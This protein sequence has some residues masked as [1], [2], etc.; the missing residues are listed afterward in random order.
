MKRFTILITLLIVALVPTA[1]FAQQ[2]EITP[3]GGYRFSDDFYDYY[4]NTRY[5]VSDGSSY[6]LTFDYTLNL[7]MQVEFLWSHQETRFNVGG[8]PDPEG[9]FNLGIDY[10]H[11]GGVQLFENGNSTPFLVGTLG[12]T[13]INP[14]DN[15]YSSDTR[16]SLAAGGGVKF[17][18]SEHLGVR[19]DGRVYGTYVNGSGGVFCGPYG[20]NFGYGGSLYWQVEFTV[21]LIFSGG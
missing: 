17:M 9:R 13:H 20:C 1:A 3:F 18:P 7:D 11:I 19:L 14:E 16:F 10:F 12:V 6:G 21:G 4:S 8:G 5:G 2:F 15:R